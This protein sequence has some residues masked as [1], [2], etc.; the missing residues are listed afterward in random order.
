MPEPE[1]EY[2]VRLE[3]GDMVVRPSRERAEATVRSI[4][5]R[6]G[7]AVL[8]SRTVVRSDWAEPDADD[9]DEGREFDLGAAPDYKCFIE[10]HIACQEHGYVCTCGCHVREAGR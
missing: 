7:T 9:A 1:I 6:G 2:A 4:R 3:D 5:A 10:D 8:V